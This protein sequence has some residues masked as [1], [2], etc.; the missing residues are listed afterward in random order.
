MSLLLVNNEKWV[1][2]QSHLEQVLV[3]GKLGGK[4]KIYQPEYLSFL[5]LGAE[6]WK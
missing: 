4:M 5:L 2:L 3:N 6:V 1:Q